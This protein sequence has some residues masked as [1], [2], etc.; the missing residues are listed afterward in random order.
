MDLY[1]LLGLARG[2]TLVEIKRSY[3]RLARKYH[4]D[5][6][7]GD[8]AAEAHFKEI[9]RAYETLSDPERRLRYDAGAMSIASTSVS[10]EFE[11]F[12]FSAGVVREST[13]FGDLFAD[14]F[15]SRQ[16]V[17]TPEPGRGADLHASVSLTFD[18]ALRG[19]E[20]R[21]TLTRRD[22][23]QSCRGA[24][25][26][27]IAEARCPRCQGSG[28]IR[29]RRGSMVF[30]KS[31]DAC[32][33]S[34][35][36]VQTTCARCAGL[37]V[38]M[39]SETINVRVPAGVPDGARI[40]VPEKG[41][42][43]ERRA[44]TGDLL[45]AVQVEPH[46]T[47]QREG[48]D[49]Y[50]TVPIGVHEA[51]LGAKIDVPAPDG[52]ARLRVPPGTQSGQRFHIRGRGAPSPRNGERGDLVAEVRIVLPKVLDERSKELLR[53]FGKINEMARGEVTPPLDKSSGRPEHDRGTQPSGVS[54]LRGPR[55]S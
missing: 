21:I 54:G 38:E 14:I 39:R 37:G 32:G 36:M 29:S 34:G 26:L 51:A 41:N 50:I 53:E 23:C 40:R 13:T 4:P 5:I 6:N 10:F 27:N 33:G 19:T 44:G 18:E 17:Q 55:D 11:G 7:P 25:A 8:N 30:S 20:R 16:D 15:T 24:G 31:C 49:L 35:R 12:D 9:T 3:K 22:T 2:A 1:E 47:F 43:G 46:E 45:I 52:T 48:D 28:V 42:A